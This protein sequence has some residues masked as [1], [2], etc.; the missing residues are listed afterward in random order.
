MEAGLVCRTPGA[1]GS[2]APTSLAR[3]K[4]WKPWSKDMATHSRCAGHSLSEGSTNQARSSPR[5]LDCG[6]RA[7]VQRVTAT[8]HGSVVS[9]PTGH[10]CTAAKP[11]CRERRRDRDVTVPG[12]AAPLLLLAY[13]N[14]IAVYNW[15][16]Q[17][18]FK[19]YTL[20]TIKIHV[21]FR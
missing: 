1:L 12:Q 18:F 17:L 6:A 19:G 9:P 2:A 3:G 20:H 16:R 5:E 4:P 15:I 8:G 7:G 21:F 13:L 11:C 14:Q 10:V